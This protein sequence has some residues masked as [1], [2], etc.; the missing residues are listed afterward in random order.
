MNGAVLDGIVMRRRSQPKPKLKQA[1]DVHQQFRRSFTLM[2]QSVSM[3]KRTPMVRS[4]IKRKASLVPA[5]SL[6]KHARKPDPTKLARAKMVGQHSKISRFGQSLAP[7]PRNIV[8]PVMPTMNRLSAKVGI[9]NRSSANA[10][11]QFDRVVSQSSSSAMVM[12]RPMTSLV[13]NTSH[14]RLEAMLDKALEQADAH[15]QMLNNHLRK[16][17]WGNLSKPR[18]VILVG[19]ILTL[20]ISVL[21]YA[22]LR[23]PA[24]SV[25]LASIR[26][27]VDGQIPSYIP[28]G[29]S[30]ASTSY[31]QG[32]IT[33]QFHK[34][35]NN[36]TLDQQS[37]GINSESLRAN[38]DASKTKLYQSSSYNGI[39]I[40]TYG[41]S[42]KLASPSTSEA[43]ASGATWVNRGIQYTITNNANLPSDQLVKIAQG[44]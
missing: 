2:R 22:Y 1:Q 17:Y 35:V 25:R 39:T 18:S 14:Q 27:G 36:F 29:F 34:G 23:V 42:S 12:A 41:N 9:T 20:L 11:A 4:D 3:P 24:V 33:L 8:S 43:N 7:L 16:S 32:D 13:A 40:Y 31:K 6:L 26:S 30:L 44:L 5:S 21:S 37:S 38:F 19:V 10:R 15:K 28:P